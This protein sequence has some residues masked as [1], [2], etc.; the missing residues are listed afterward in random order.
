MTFSELFIILCAALLIISL[1]KELIVILLIVLVVLAIIWMIYP[2]SNI[3]ESE[4]F[5]D[6]TYK[7]NYNLKLGELIVAHASDDGNV[8]YYV[9]STTPTMD[10]GFFKQK[11]DNHEYK[12]ITVRDSKDPRHLIL[13]VIPKVDVTTGIPEYVS[14]DSEEYELVNNLRNHPEKYRLLYTEKDIDTAP[15]SITRKPSQLMQPVTDIFI[16]TLH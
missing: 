13:N 15:Y 1:A 8:R 2:I 14:K 7:T 11:I 5:A 10:Y 12:F 9:I 3:T 6:I 4:R 16:Q